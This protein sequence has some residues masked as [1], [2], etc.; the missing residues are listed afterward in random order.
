[1]GKSF[2]TKNPRLFSRDTAETQEPED[3]ESWL[4]NW[5]KWPVCLEDEKLK[6]RLLQG[7]PPISRVKSPQETPC[8]SGHLP[9]Y[10]RPFTGDP[11]FHVTMIVGWMS[12]EVSKWLVNGL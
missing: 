3:D 9:N 6:L 2:L 10:F 12:Q 4:N 5:T 1:M 11:E 7:A 8:I